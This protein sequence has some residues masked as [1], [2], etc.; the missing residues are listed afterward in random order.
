MLN[1]RIPYAEVFSTVIASL[2]AGQNTYFTIPIDI[3]EGFI[4]G[5]VTLWCGGGTSGRIP[6]LYSTP[7]GTLYGFVRNENDAGENVTVFA[8]CIFVPAKS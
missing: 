7:N 4:V 2:P 1:S 3:P 6:V 5:G 8:E